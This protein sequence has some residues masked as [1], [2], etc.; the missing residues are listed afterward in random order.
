MTRAGTERRVASRGHITPD[1]GR[2]L[3]TVHLVRVSALRSVDSPRHRLEDAEHLRSLMASEET[4]PPITVHRPTMRVVDGVHRLKVAVLRGRTEIEVQFLDGTAQDAFVHAVEANTRHGLPLSLAE[5]SA[6]AERILGSHPHLADRAIASIAGVSAHTVATLRRD[7]SS[8]DG[9]PSRVGRDG[10]VR[11]LSTAQSRREAEQ[12]LRSAQKLP[13]RE[14]ARRT[15]LSP[16]TVRD[17]RNRMMRGE[18]AVPGRQRAG[19]EQEQA[20]SRL[21]APEGT[22][23]KRFVPRP[24]Q[25]L[26]AAY[27]QLCRDP[28]LRQSQTGRLLL[29]LLGALT[30]S[31]GEWQGIA[32]GLPAHRAGAIAELAAECA[33]S[34]GEFGVHVRERTAG[35]DGAQ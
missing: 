29:R 14:I 15:G 24:D 21:A 1:E 28:S 22:Q 7:G 9:P 8:G 12:L 11:P 26:V 33:R 30:L 32:A 13:L 27:R 35:A 25:D 2:Q 16:A 23:P 31:E 3:T 34:W 10:R 20:R 4:F 18:D 5:R 6:A 17:V 19:E